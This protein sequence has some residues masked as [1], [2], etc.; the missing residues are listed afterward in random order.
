VQE[1]AERCRECLGADCG[2]GVDRIAHAGQRR[3]VDGH[4][5]ENES[6][7]NLPDWQ[8]LTLRIGDGAWL[9]L[10]AVSVADY[11]QELDLRRGVLTRRF[12]IEDAEGRR[13]RVAQRRLVSMADPFLAALDCTLVAEN[14]SG[15]LTARGPG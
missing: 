6:I 7:V 12:R 4:H 11:V 2:A 3:E 8:S 14:W 9:D 1:T 15:A 10:S 13:T 5:L